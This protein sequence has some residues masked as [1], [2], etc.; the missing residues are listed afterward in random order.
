[1]D[2]LHPPVS[3]GVFKP[4]GHVVVSFPSEQDL[5]GAAQA[6]RESG[7]G[8]DRVT[9]YTPGEMT[10]Q[11]EHDIEHAGLLASVGQDLNL[12]KAH[13]MLAQQGYHFL[14]VE[15]PDEAQARGVAERV[16]P[17]HAERAQRYGRFIVEELIAHPDDQAQVAES[18]DRGLDAQTPSGLEIERAQRHRQ[19]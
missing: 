7:F 12:V 11:A 2:K 16:K 1:M 6:L 3:H 10:R 8:D 15:A 9:R 17:F 5:Q 14:V 18:P 19:R 13:Q 4:V